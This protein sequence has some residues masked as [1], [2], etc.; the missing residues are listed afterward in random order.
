MSLGREAREQ[1]S[2]QMVTREVEKRNQFRVEPTLDDQAHH[3]TIQ[4][5]IEAVKTK[6]P[7]SK[8]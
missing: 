4:S 8:L 5:T 1:L 6:Q 3:T 2:Q 7:K